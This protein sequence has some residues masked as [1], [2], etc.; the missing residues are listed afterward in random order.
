MLQEC[1]LRLF[2][3]GR[4]AA[5]KRAAMSVVWAVETLEWIPRSA[6]DTHWRKAQAE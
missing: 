6:E 3:V 4:K 5:M 2:N 1:V